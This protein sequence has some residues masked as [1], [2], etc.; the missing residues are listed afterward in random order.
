[1]R[2]GVHMPSIDQGSSHVL[3]MLGALSSVLAHANAAQDH[4]PHRGF[5]NEDSL[6]LW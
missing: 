2:M 5:N 1:M 3:Y 6:G 4:C